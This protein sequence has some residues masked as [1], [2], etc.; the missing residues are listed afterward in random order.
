MRSDLKSLLMIVSPL[1]DKKNIC[2][3]ICLYFRFYY[4]FYGVFNYYDSV[5][6]YYDGVF[7]Y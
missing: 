2:D 7:N 6:N 3:I 1:A 5:F 4:Q